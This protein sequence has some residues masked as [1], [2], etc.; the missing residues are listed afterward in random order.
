MSNEHHHP[1]SGERSPTRGFIVRVGETYF[2][3]KSSWVYSPE[4]RSDEH[5]SDYQKVKRLFERGPVL[6]AIQYSTEDVPIV[7]VGEELGSPR[8]GV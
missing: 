4:A 3:A 2:F 5:K 7:G 6:N 1:G 8:S